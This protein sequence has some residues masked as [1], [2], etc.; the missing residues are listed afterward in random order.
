MLRGA[1]DQ[2]GSDQA[3]DSAGLASCQLA[4]Y[5]LEGIA[6]TIRTSVE[7]LS[8]LDGLRRNH[9]LG[10]LARVGA[11]K[12]K[13]VLVAVCG[14]KIVPTSGF[15][16]CTCVATEVAYH[17]K[18]FIEGRVEFLDKS[19]W[20]RE[21]STLL[22]DLNELGSDAEPRLPWGKLENATVDQIAWHKIKSVYPSITLRELQT[23]TADDILNLDPGRLLFSLLHCFFC[24]QFFIV[25]TTELLGHD[26]EVTGEDSTS[27]AKAINKY[28]GSAQGKKQQ[29]AATQLSPAVWPLIR[30]VR[31]FCKS[32]ALES[33]TVLVDLPGLGDSN[34]A[35]SDVA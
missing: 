30:Q 3:S 18:S 10:D 34:E 4:F 33:G 29:P 27:F 7:E 32:P 28:I 13:P 2:E 17:S 16:A 24:Y 20:K 15:E 19:D 8:Q 31:I 6:G 22:Y 35:R 26:V 25:D 9:W 12:N 11:S 14:D 5:A 21:L 23:M 1:A